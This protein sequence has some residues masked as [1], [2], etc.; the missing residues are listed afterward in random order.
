MNATETKVVADYLL[1]N[2]EHEMQ[3]TLRVIAAVPADQPGYAPDPTSK[4]ALPLVRHI[5]L[6]EEWFLNSIADGQFSAPPKDS[7]DSSGIRT[8]QEAA[9]YY[10]SKMPAALDRVRGM[11]GEQLSKL[12]DFFGMAQLP[13]VDVL[14]LAL[15]HSVHHRGQLSTYIR[16]MGGRVPGIYGPSADSAKA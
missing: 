5:V 4:S 6:D 8:L 2:F 11:S 10:Q 3:T 12:I 15:K 7:D 14:A 9:A 13:G 1:V 16:P